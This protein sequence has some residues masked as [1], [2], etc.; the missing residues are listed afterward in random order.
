MEYWKFKISKK[1]I[2]IYA[3][4]RHDFQIWKKF[5]SFPGDKKLKRKILGKEVEEEENLNNRLQ[6]EPRI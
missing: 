3:N 6:F 1:K 5:A 2:K 4:R